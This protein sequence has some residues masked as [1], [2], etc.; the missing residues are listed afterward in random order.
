[1]VS[2]SDLD[3]KANLGV[4]S[5]LILL[6]S[7]NSVPNLL[8]SAFTYTLND[9]T[10]LQR[11]YNFYQGILI[12]IISCRICRDSRSKLKKRQGQLG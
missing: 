9:P 7:V 1:M 2:D 3:W 4:T 6:F 8:L 5:Y 12:I 10:D 11:R